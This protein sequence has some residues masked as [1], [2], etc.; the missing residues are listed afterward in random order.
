VK[1]ELLIPLFL[2]FS[3]CWLNS[4]GPAINKKYDFKNVSNINIDIIEDFSN[5]PRSGEMIFSNLTHNFL[6]FNFDVNKSIVKIG[7]GKSELLLSCV[8]TEFTDSKMVVVPYRHEDRG[9]TKTVIKQL[10]NNHDDESKEGTSSQRQT[11]TI[12]THAGKIN[13]GNKVEYSQCR[14]G[15][16][17]KLSDL[18]TGSLVWS[19]SYWYSGLEMQRTIELCLKNLVSHL[20]K[21]FK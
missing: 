12:T 20:D 7:G 11:S 1:Q 9:Y 13:E 4:H 14:V 15:V 10:S 5:A 8:I 21:L 3:S 6:K 2:V 18:S 16:L 17:I 19:H